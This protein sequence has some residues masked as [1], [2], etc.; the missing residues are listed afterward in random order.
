MTLFFQQGLDHMTIRFQCMATIG[1]CSCSGEP[2]HEH[3][4][5]MPWPFGCSQLNELT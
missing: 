2:G 3:C 1:Y 4:Q 5:K